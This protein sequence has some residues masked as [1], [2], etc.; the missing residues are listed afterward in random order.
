MDSRDL[1][2]AQGLFNVANG[3]WPLVSMRSFEK[4]LGPK[5]E[6][7]LVRTVAGLMITNGVA[8]V[9]SSSVAE[10]RSARRIGLGTA[11]TLGLIDVRYGLPGRIRRTYLLDAFVQCGWIIAWLRSSRDPRAGVISANS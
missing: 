7:W 1:T 11:A 4:V 8:Q 10:P 6:H 5:A 9:R 3:L 2:R